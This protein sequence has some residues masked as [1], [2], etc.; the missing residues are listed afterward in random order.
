MLAVSVRGHILPCTYTWQSNFPT[1]RSK[2]KVIRAG[3]NFDS[4]L[5]PWHTKE[6]QR[7]CWQRISIAWLWRCTKEAVQQNTWSVMTSDGEWPQCANARGHLSGWSICHV[8]HCAADLVVCRQSIRW[9]TSS[10]QLYNGTSTQRTSK[11]P[12]TV[13]NKR[14]LSPSLQ[15]Q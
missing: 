8:D 14:Y 10:S 15:F 6:L 5:I 1:E 4:T 3:W 12:S 13:C 7:T 2:I 11:L 9:T